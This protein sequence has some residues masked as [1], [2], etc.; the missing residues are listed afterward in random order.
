M[1]LRTLASCRPNEPEN[2]ST[3]RPNEAKVHLRFKSFSNANII[4]PE[5]PAEKN[6]PA[7]HI[8][9]N[10]FCSG[11][12]VTLG[13]AAAKRIHESRVAVSETDGAKIP[14]PY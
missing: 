3:R 2:P 9:L 11:H 5:V 6:E 8:R 13:Q 7:V 14:I 12:F 1:N 10:A 4:K